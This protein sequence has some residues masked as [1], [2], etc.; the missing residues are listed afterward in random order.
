MSIRVKTISFSFPMGL[1]WVAMCCVTTASGQTIHLINVADT[2]DAKIGRSCEEDMGNVAQ[3]FFFGFPERMLH[4]TRLNGDQVTVENIT[5]AIEQTP[6]ESNDTLVFF[7]SGHGGYDVEKKEHFLNMPQG[8]PLYRSTLLGALQKKSARL[9]V[10]L[11][12][13]CA[14]FVDTT[15]GLQQMAPASPDPNRGVAPL[16]DELFLKARGVVD[17]N[18]AAPGEVALGLQGGGLF[19]MLLASSALYEQPPDNTPRPI[20]EYMVGYLW[21]NMERR[22]TWKQMVGQ[23]QPVAQKLFTAVHPEG[24]EHPAGPRQTTQTITAFALPREAA[25]ADDRGSRFGVM[26]VA[27]GSDGV[28]VTSVRRGYPGTRVVVIATGE[29]LT[30]QA[31]DVILEVNGQE[32]H[33]LQDYVDTVRSSPPTMDFTVRNVNNG[34]KIRLRTKLMY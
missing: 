3:I 30:L 11:T 31:G 4:E 8:G 25:V 29:V 7:W 27:N 1:L 14:N 6:V 34:D 24:I 19:G 32:I 16:F 12:D 15:A 17:I 9:T 22:A 28:R 23:M 21:A 13:S 20:N 10:L 26:A 33:S 2:A 18:A 5:A